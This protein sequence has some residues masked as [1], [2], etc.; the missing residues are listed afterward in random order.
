MKPASAETIQL[1]KCVSIL[2]LSIALLLSF[3]I[4]TYGQ[5]SID[6]R[7][8]EEDFGEPL[9]KAIVQIRES[10]LYTVTNRFGY[11]RMELP[12]AFFAIEAIHPLV[13]SEFYNTTTYEDIYTPVGAIRLEPKA[14]GR[15]EQRYLAARN[16]PVQHPGAISNTPM[17]NMMYQSGSSDF[18]ELFE[19]QP[20]TYLVENGSAYNSSEIRVRGFSTTQN[21]V[22]FNGISLN[23]PESG[24]MNT[25]LYAGMS[26]WAQDVQFTTGITSGKQSELGQ[27]SLINV[28][29]FMP[30]K[31]FGV[32]VSASASVNS[33][34]KIAATVHSG[35]S[36]K[37]TAFSLMLDRN[38]GDG[39]PDFTGFTS[40]GAYLNVYKEINHRHSLFLTSINRNWTSDQRTRPDSIARI[41][42]FG[43]NHN[44]DSGLLNN[45]QTGWNKHFG[46]SSLNILTH[47][48]HMQVQSRLVSQLYLEVT[49]QVHSYPSGSI[50]G[51][52]PYE[53][54]ASDRGLVNFDTIAQYNSGKTISAND[55][56]ATLGGVS[57]STRWGLQTQYI[58]KIDEITHLSLSADMENYSASHYGA[59]NDLL[60]ADAFTDQSNVN[61]EPITVNSVL[62]S[63]LFPK[64][65]KVDKV[66]H[67]Y[68][69][70]IRKAGIAARLEQRSNRTFAYGELGVYAKNLSREDYFNYLDNSSEQKSDG[71]NQLGWRAAGGLTYRLN[72]AHS[73]RLNLGASSAPT[74][75]DILF[76]AGNNWENTAAKNTNQYTGELAYVLSKA[77]YFV[78]LRGYMTY[79]QNRTDIQRYGLNEGEQFAVLSG[80]AQFHRGAELSGQVTYFKRFNFY[81]NAS[82]GKWTFSKDAEAA[83]YNDATELLSTATLPL[84]SY[85]TDNAPPVSIY[86][87]NEFN[88]LKGLEL[89]VNY[90]RSFK[91]FAP[92]LVHDFDET[93]T[94][95]QLE[96]PSFDRLGAGLNYYLELRN[97][98]SLNIFADVRNLLG[99]EYINHIYTNNEDFRSN[100]AHY[101]KGMSW[102]AGVSFCF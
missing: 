27:S 47:Y 53:L 88:L 20:S 43:I 61:A 66:D 42:T 50:D 64:T 12:E 59:L 6:G 75:F 84:K 23:N 31:E 74:R 98:R 89:N 80:L 101:G 14:V 28:L 72:E 52:N 67:Y 65:G 58:H 21:Q 26:D 95:E 16:N 40:Y 96:L 82:V 90:Y 5:A 94:P 37:K 1:R 81:L 24:R 62:S 68:E 17:L 100:L 92:L 55:G 102:R 8:T 49:N 85:K 13:Y 41:S 63:S 46:I 9:E 99:S 29:P 86:L 71:V 25:G 93:L 22:V 69:S 83:I 30:K 2:L 44:N 51:Q 91:T 4:Q 57:R 36:R 15:M 3:D 87:K 79:Q 34:L 10:G 7:V 76:P 19:G 39:I 38:S 70:K 54:E 77:R 56:I 73:A 60:T 45:A 33:G 48:W 35:M 11:F 18:N 32:K 97:N 78:S